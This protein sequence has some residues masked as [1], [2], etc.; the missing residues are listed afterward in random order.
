MGTDA[1]VGLAWIGLALSSKKMTDSFCVQEARR[2][3]VIR[4]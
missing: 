1:V 4:I 3:H 2:N